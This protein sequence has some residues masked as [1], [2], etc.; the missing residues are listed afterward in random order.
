[1][2]L[3]ALI[4]YAQDDPSTADVRNSLMDTVTN[5][6]TFF[7]AADYADGTTRWAWP[8]ILHEP[9]A[10]WERMLQGDAS[11]GN[12]MPVAGAAMAGSL[13]FARN[14]LPRMEPSLLGP[15]IPAPKTKPSW[16]TD[17]AASLAAYGGHK[18]TVLD[19]PAPNYAPLLDRIMPALTEMM[20]QPQSANVYHGSWK[21]DVVTAPKRDVRGL[22]TSTRPD[23]ADTYTEA[24]LDNGGIV[25]PARASFQRPLVV[26]AGGAKY[27]RIPIKLPDGK[28]ETI[29]TDMLA[30][31][32]RKLEADGLIVRDVRDAAWGGDIP[33]DI[34]HAI[35][36]KTVQGRYSPEYLYSGGR[37]A[38]AGGLF[39]M[40]GDQDR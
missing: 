36:P 37:G 6:A 16:M 31:I 1:M 38:A 11:P 24:G 22:W 35:K 34:W 9:A 17:D 8:G 4:G 29:S 2:T 20:A 25:A 40:Y 26:D 18:S 30:L 32:A 5:R 27:S 7:P 10:A 33:S 23:I 13:P 14:Q 19:A 12:A 39:S 15:I 21:P 28:T 3:N